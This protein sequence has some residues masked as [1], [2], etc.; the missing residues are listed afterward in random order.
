MVR[1]GEYDISS[2]VS[3]DNQLKTGRDLSAIYDSYAVL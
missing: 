3:I 2:N 1:T